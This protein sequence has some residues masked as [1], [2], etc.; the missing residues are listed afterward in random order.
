MGIFGNR[1][2]YAELFA[3][4]Y[5]EKD[6]SIEE[7]LLFLRD[8][9]A[10]SIDCIMVLAENLDI[11]LQDADEMVLNSQAWSDIQKITIEVKGHYEENPENPDENA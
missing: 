10:S 3:Q 4:N 5:Q 6:K 2:Y 7:M 11:S 9:G 1:K 8:K